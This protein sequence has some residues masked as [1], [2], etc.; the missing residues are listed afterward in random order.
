MPEPSQVII[1]RAPG[2]AGKAS[3]I[4][5]AMCQTNHAPLEPCK[6]AWVSLSTAYPG[7]T[8]KGDKIIFYLPRPP[9]CL[10]S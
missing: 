7:G 5:A 4:E 8:A 6:H 1:R 3:V 2:A 10:P 9:F